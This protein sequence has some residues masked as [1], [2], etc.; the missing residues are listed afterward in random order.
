MSFDCSRSSPPPDPF[1]FVCPLPFLTMYLITSVEYH[2]PTFVFFIYFGLL[3]TP[4]TINAEY[5]KLL[6]LNIDIAKSPICTCH[7]K[8]YDCWINNKKVTKV[9]QI[10]NG[11]ILYS[12]TWRLMSLFSQNARLWRNR[13]QYRLLS[14]CFIRMF[15]QID[16]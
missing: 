1:N 15:Q 11:G 8:S 5:C 13:W 14:V 4:N 16:V 10:I 12:Q 3:F 2:S 9:N 7:E 6:T